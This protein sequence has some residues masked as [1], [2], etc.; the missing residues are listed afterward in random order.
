VSVTGLL[1]A[2]LGRFY[3]AWHKY[4][5]WQRVPA[6]CWDRELKRVVERD[7]DGISVGWEYRMRCD[8]T[9]QGRTYTVTPAPCHAIQFFTRAQLERFL[10]KHIAADGRCTLWINPDNPLECVFPRRPLIE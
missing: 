2:F 5:G 1:I 6:T 9:Y 8:V 4:R 7:S 3:A 10:N